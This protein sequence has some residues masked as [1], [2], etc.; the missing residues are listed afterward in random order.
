MNSQKNTRSSLFLIELMISV[1]FFALGSAICIQVFVKA[2][3]VNED[4]RRLSFASLQVSSAASALKY[5]DGS[6]AS[7]KEYFPLIQ[8]EGTGFVL[9]YDKNFRACEQKDCFFVLHMTRQQEGNAI[10]ARIYMNAP[11]RKEPLYQLE[12]RYPAA[13]ALSSDTEISGEKEGDLS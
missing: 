8:E 13:R 7:M 3:T 1:L 10:S 2:Y 9:C 6:T 12:L 11:D 4:A 5:T